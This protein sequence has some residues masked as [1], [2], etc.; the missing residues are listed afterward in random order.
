MIVCTPVFFLAPRKIA[1]LVPKFW[2]QSSISGCM[3]VIAG[4]DHEIRGH[5]EHPGGRLH[6]RAEAPVGL[7][8]LSRCCRWLDDPIYILK[9]ELM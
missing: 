4:T 7:G 9:R 3:Q 6:L 8:H 5:G 2:A 1:W